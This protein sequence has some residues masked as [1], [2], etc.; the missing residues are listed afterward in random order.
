MSTL[1]Q[2]KANLI[3]KYNITR[4]MLDRKVEDKDVAALARIILDWENIALQLLNK[5]DRENITQNG[6]GTGQ[7]KQMLLETWQDRN[8]DDATFDKLITAMV[9][10]G[11]V[12]QATDVCKLLNPSQ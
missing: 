1:Q 9:D 10:A 8:G 3:G 6:Q 4:A 2:Q 7:K 11:E 5:I 12:G